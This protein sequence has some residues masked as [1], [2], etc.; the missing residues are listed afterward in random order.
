[1]EIRKL[2]L[3]NSSPSIILMTTHT[4]DG[5][6]YFAHHLS[7]YLASNGFQVFFIE[8]TPQRWPKNILSDLGSWLRKKKQ[9]NSNTFTEVNNIQIITPRWLPPAKWLRF[10]NRIIIRKD[11]RKIN[12][13]R[14]N[15]HIS[16][17]LILFP[18]TY[19]TLDF[20][21]I[22]QPSSIAYVNNFNYAANNIMKDL[23]VSEI[24]IL[25]RCNALFGLTDFCANRV[26]LMA[27]LRTTYT[28]PPGVNYD[29]FHKAFRGDESVQCKT[30]Y[31][32]GGI[33]PHLDFAVYDALADL[34]VH[35][36]M[37][38]IVD[39]EIRGKLNS[40]FEI[41]PPSLH[42]QLPTILRDADCL[43]IAYK[44]TEYMKGVFPAK[45]FECLATGK[46]L[47]V[48]GMPELIPYYDV[49]YNVEGSGQKAISIIKNL[50]ITET[51]ERIRKR[52]KIA[53]DADW[54]KRFETFL[55]QFNEQKE[56]SK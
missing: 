48:S 46:P 56:N 16:P 53:Q 6:Q 13:L 28:C 39:P 4:W 54:A 3:L 27:P 34:G 5:L 47:L 25:S 7:K 49:V 18:P 38:G 35:I 41:R 40:K 12:Q 8:K 52:D 21:D 10:F 1:M 50:S 55:C 15:C 23:L 14:E 33:G 20:I 26:K 31:Y 44:S 17:I 45:F 29:A 51:L 24:E 11:I 22:I 30:A 2:E 19:N 36:V 37:D 32:F 9:Q 42:S 43:V